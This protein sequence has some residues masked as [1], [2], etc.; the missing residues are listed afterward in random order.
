MKKGKTWANANAE[1][2]YF[3]YI[4]GKAVTCESE[5]DGASTSTANF[6]SAKELLEHFN[7][8]CSSECWRSCPHAISAADKYE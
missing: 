5:L 8:F 6:R 7:S 4:T 3:K 1:C 2:P